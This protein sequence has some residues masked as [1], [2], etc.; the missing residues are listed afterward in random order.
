MRVPILNKKISFGYNKFEMAK[1]E[2]VF[3]DGMRVDLFAEFPVKDYSSALAW[4][5]R[6]LGCPPAFLPNDIEAVWE[7]AEN[8]YVYIK[9]HPEHAG[10][11]FSLFS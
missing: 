7:L 11:A 9:V 8:R 1:S 2:K 4:Y 10:H 5:Q 6:L 3:S